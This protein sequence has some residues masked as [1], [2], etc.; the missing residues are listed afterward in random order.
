LAVLLFSLE[1]WGVSLQRNFKATGVNVPGRSYLDKDAEIRFEL[2]PSDRSPGSS[3]E[4][5]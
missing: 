4:H 1:L 5:E 3:A 2:L